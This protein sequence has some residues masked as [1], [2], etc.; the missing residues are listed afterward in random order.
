MQSGEGQEIYPDFLEEK[1]N[2]ALIFSMMGD[3]KNDNLY[4]KEGED[5]VLVKEP[6]PVSREKF[7][8]IMNKIFKKK[9]NN[10]GY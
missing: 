8:E 4:I 3:F 7:N 10:D 9:G 1:T 5:F 2:D 6:E